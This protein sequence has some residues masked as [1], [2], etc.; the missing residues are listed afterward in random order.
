ME[1][2]DIAKEIIAK[3]GNNFHSKVVERFRA[4][5]WSVSISPYYLDGSTNKAREIDLVAEIAKP[6]NTFFDQS[7]RGNVSIKLFVECKYIPKVN[8]FWFDQIN[9]SSALSWLSNNLPG[10]AHKVLLEKH[11]YLTS[12]KQVAKLFGSENGKFTE[13]EPFYKAI[14][15]SLNSVVNL[16]GASSVIPNDTNGY[17]NPPLFCLEMP[18]IVC[19]C[20]DKLYSTSID[21]ESAPVKIDNYFKIE[22]DYAY[23]DS[24]KNN[25]SEY[26]LIDVVDFNCIEKYFEYLEADINRIMEML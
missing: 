16:R 12:G 13:N 23:V 9:E 4:S 19:N 24:R 20:F 22:I 17:S 10:D 6:Y 7:I 8:V 11:H 26:F 18:V 3:S 2:L 21:G 1:E 5:G 25:I 14:N 15:Q